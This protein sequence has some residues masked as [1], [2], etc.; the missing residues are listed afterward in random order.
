M[1]NL[2]LHPKTQT[3]DTCLSTDLSG[4]GTDSTAFM[5]IPHKKSPRV[6]STGAIFQ[7]QIQ[8]F[9][10]YFHFSVDIIRQIVYNC[11]TFLERGYVSL[12]R[13]VQRSER[14]RLP[15]PPL[16]AKPPISVKVLS[17]PLTWEKGR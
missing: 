5:K 8:I 13:S 17:H 11:Y 10:L 2:F 15:P 12:T 1:Q 7:P 6:A 16:L 4:R 14:H 3:V 9:H